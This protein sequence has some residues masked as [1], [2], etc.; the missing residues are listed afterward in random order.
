MKELLK[1]QHGTIELADR[2]LFENAN[3]IIK[4]G[5]VIGIIGRNGSGK[6]TLLNVIA[7]V[8]P[9]TSGKRKW[10]QP[11]T[12][13]YLVEQEEQHFQP[14]MTTE[15]EAVLLAKWKV[16]DVLYEKLSGGE[17]LKR[18]LAKGF[19]QSPQIL[20]L[21]EPTNH[22]DAVS[23]Q[24]LIDRIKAYSGTIILVSHDR[25]FLDEVTTKIWSLEQQQ[26]IEQQGNYSHY[27]DV[28][29]QRRLAQQRAYEKQQKKI[30][31]LEQQMDALTSWS[32][33]AHRD[34]TK[35][36]FPKEYYR[37]K[38][39]RMDAQVK[40]KRKML[41]KEIEKNKVEQVANEQPVN[42]R[43]QAN[44]KVGKRFLQAKN[45]SKYFGERRLFEQVNFTILHGERVALIGAN[46][47][48]KTTFLNMILGR[49]SFDGE[50]SFSP[51]TNIG[52]LTQEVFDLPEHQ[53][54]AML[55]HRDNFTDRGLVQNLMRHL[56][57]HMEQWR[58]PIA[59]MS[60][61]ERVKC[62]LMQYILE[63][64]DVLI[65]DEP[66]NHLDLP[67]REQLES[68]LAQYKGTLILVSH[69]QYFID[70]LANM[71]LV[72]QDGTIQKKAFG[73]SNA[74]KNTTEDQLLQLETARQEVLGKLSFMTSKDT[75][76]SM[77]DAQ[78]LELTQQI[79]ALRKR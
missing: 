60:M 13:V 55:F 45:V 69:D 65:L 3:A 5:E 36:E 12:S 26:F 50:L 56:G 34:S 73:Q 9:F 37:V 33:K 67:S 71:H 27:M 28:R 68:T 4:Q 17:R 6:S 38:A 57:F 75:N 40:S 58:E 11:D 41:E 22:L 76:Y 78:F 52:Y 46:G 79:N 44:N 48:G 18:R 51:T 1:L 25:Y 20:L 43:L 62:K 72:I 42:F 54:P 74:Q 31:I 8:R 7:G 10:L 14:E 77:L 16:P 15:E 53:T 63:N 24:S 49:E 21:D 23:T 66:T 64:R 32:Q 47:S 2:I 59:H 61:G 30:D 19:S 29:E 35:Q 39:K 70:K